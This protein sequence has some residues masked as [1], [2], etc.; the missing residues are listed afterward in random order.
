[1]NPIIRRELVGLLRTPQSV[2]LQLVFI[3]ALSL[4]V[5]SRW[6]ITGTV[7]RAAGQSQQVVRFFGY[8]MFL[9]VS[10]LAPI[11]PATS[12]VRERRKGT[13]LL[14][15]NSPLSASSI[16]VGKL[17]GGLGFVML[18]LCLSLPVAAACYSMGG[19]NLVGTL[20]PLY[21]LLVILALQFAS[22]GLLVSTFAATPESAVRVTYMI[23]A[24]LTILP[25][26]LKQLMSTFAAG[27]AEWAQYLS[28]LPAL[29]ELLGN[30]DIANAA[31]GAFTGLDAQTRNRTI[32]VSL[33]L[34]ALFALG[35]IARLNT[36][37]F[38]RARAAGKITDE[39]GAFVRFYRRV[40]YLWFFDPQRRSTGIGPLTN[41]VMMKEFRTR[42]FGR[43]N[44]IIRMGVLALIV[45]LALMLAV[46]REI[47]SLARESVAAVV[48]FLQM[49]LIVLITPTL[50]CGL[51]SGERESGGWPLLQ[52]TPLSATRIVTG[53][54]LSAC[55]PVL[56][57]LLATLPSYIMLYLIGAIDSEPVPAVVLS[58]ILTTIFSVLISAA[59]SSLF[60]R[61]SDATI[62]TF[63]TLTVLWGGTLL[64]WAAEDAPLPRSVVQTVLK[65]N[66]LAT[67]LALAQVPGFKAYSLAPANW[68]LMG[69]ASVA[70]LIVLVT[71]TARLT[72][73]D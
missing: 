62:A 31:A 20:V 16:F 38:D 10:L 58:L 37:L 21:F 70:C 22:L 59:F 52:M 5:I 46:N 55:V 33:V 29:L 32:I 64:A 63:A 65:I 17:V 71:R 35:C 49:G 51:I 23:L 54:L 41:P 48:I 8:G 42:R 2:L 15:I 9:G 28:P 25:L 53:K 7:D 27:A 4:L 12:I 26:A 73:P 36:R 39:R 60:K 40:M 67:S 6:P 44:W 57:I 24:A 56:L 68:W 11:F 45:S 47:I 66:P 19:I 18:L 1:M 30:V 61:T 50:A 43:S 72:R 3:A 34:T 69:L 13:L 14:L